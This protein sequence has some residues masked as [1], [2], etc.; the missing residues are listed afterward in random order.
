[1]QRLCCVFAVEMAL[2]RRRTR[3]VLTVPVRLNGSNLSVAL[4]VLPT[5]R[6]ATQA[7]TTRS[8]TPSVDLFVHYYIYVIIN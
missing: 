2:I 8:E 1:V 6:L 5:S 4:M 7:A 3:A